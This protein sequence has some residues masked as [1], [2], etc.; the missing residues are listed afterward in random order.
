LEIPSAP[1]YVAIVRHAVEGIAQRMQ[2]SAA[3]IEDLKVAV[4]EACTNAIKYGCPRDDVHNVE[5]RCMVRDDGLLVEIR[6]SVA[7]CESPVVPSVPDLG[8]E[9]GLGLYLIR[10]LMDEVD[11]QWNHDTAVVTMLK[12]L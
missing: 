9:G 8:R 7:G 11:F 5:I 2:F 4:G 10:Q 6:N 1:E 3:Q 12:R